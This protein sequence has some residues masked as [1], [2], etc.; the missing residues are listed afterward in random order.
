[1]LQ[2]MRSAAKWIWIGLFVAFVGGFLLVDTSGLLGRS[3]VTPTTEVAEVNGQGIL[4]TT[5]QTATQQLAEQREQQLG[6]GL[7]LDERQRVEQ[8]A[9]DQLVSDILLQQ[10]YR[11]RGISVTDEEIIQAARV[12]PPPQL[13][14]AP[15]LQ[16]EGRFDPDKYQRYLTS[17]AARQQGLL[18]MLEGYYRSEIPRQKLL[19]QLT[20]DVYVTDSRLW[21]VYRDAN[22]S[23]QISYVAFR[24]DAVADSQV[25]VTDAQIRE[26]FDRHK[27]DLTR[28]GRAVV[29]VLAVPRTITA[30]DSA[31]VRDRLMA[32][33]AEIAA[34][35][36]FEDVARRETADSASIPQGGLYPLGPRGRFVREFEEAAY[37][38]QPGE[39]SGPVLTQYGYHLLK[40]EERRGDSIA[41]RHIL[42]KIGQSDS[43]AART[44]RRA[45]SLANM[46][47]EATQPTQFDNAS[48]VLKLPSVRLTAIEGEPLLMGGRYVPSVSAWAF[49]GVAPGETSELFDDENGYYLARLDSVVHGGEPRLEQVRD[50][51]RAIIAR[52]R[53]LDRLTAEA[54]QFAQ[55]A[56]T[57][58]LEAAAA[59][60]GIQVQQTPVFTRIAPVPGLGQLNQAI[61]AAFGLPLNQVGGPVRTPGA[62]FVMRVDRRMPADSA[63]F[64]AQ[65]AAQRAQLLNGLRR[66]RVQD[67]LQSLRKMAK[68]KDR[69]RELNAAMRNQDI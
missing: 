38:M 3:A 55:A 23:A 68:I 32:L 57:S 59:A 49:S 17:P 6:R 1:M 26:Y 22:D 9:F 62:L 43:A 24:P 39:M 50:E 52:E 65:K 35:A 20:T 44:D 34:G 58:G 45:D 42:L 14:Q 41:I 30:A 27:A 53:K 11:R 48:R 36:R 7:T 19:D 60:R 29:S 56:R 69:R 21:Q 12:S 25:Q 8:E 47:A 16:T 28:P 13:M 67:Y 40:T 15:E 2:Q 66:Q 37:G 5:L 64:A 4:Y 33:R 61:G 18:S 51:I 31:A 46:A 63:T 10:E 54:T